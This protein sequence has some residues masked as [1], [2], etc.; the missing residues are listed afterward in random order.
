MVQEA[1]L[2]GA[3]GSNGLAVDPKPKG[4]P[5]G[6]LDKVVS[7]TRSLGVHHFAFVRSSLLGLDIDEA[8]DRYMAWTGGRA[9]PRNVPRRLAETHQHVLQA[10]HYMNSTL[11]PERQITR[12]LDLLRSVAPQSVQTL[13]TLEEWMSAEGID[14]DMWSEAEALAEYKMAHGIDSPDAIEDAR[15]LAD[16]VRGRVEALNHLQTLLAILPRPVDPLDMWFARPVA[17]QLRNVGLLTLAN[18]VDFINVYGYR[19]HEQV[20]GLGKRRAG[21]VIAWLRS[22]ADALQLEL[23][24]TVD[25]AKTVRALRLGS[26]PSQLVVP[27]RFG[28]VPLEQLELPDEL[29]GRSGVFRSHMPNTLEADDDLQAI[30]A[31]LTRYGEK[32]ATARSYRK[33]IERFVLWCATV[34]RKSVSSIS[35]IDCKAFRAFMAA[36][37]ADWIHPVPVERT[38]P[39]W[40]PFR[41]QPEPRR[42]SSR[43]SSSRRCSKA[44]AMPATWSQ[45]RCGR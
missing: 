44:Y 41:K 37:P 26:S 45:T 28:L 8:F 14:P 17:V 39:H 31:W 1:F 29:L 40:R 22:R 27:K 36:V 23:R 13:P 4:R 24:A 30:R 38:D 11:P 15:G 21:R 42:R 2:M 34:Q 9:E 43:S 7:S 12:Q 32:P 20:K 19:W 33:E 16:A 6:V 5:R 25:E 10:G 35:A 18:L 3:V